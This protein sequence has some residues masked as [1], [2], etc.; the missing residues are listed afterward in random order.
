[1]LSEDDTSVDVDVVANLCVADVVSLC[2]TVDDDKD[3]EDD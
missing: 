1:M 2:L 3:D